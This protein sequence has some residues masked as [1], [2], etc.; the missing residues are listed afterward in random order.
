MSIYLT[1]VHHISYHQARRVGG[2]SPAGICTCIEG[3]QLCQSLPWAPAS[4][5]GSRTS[6]PLAADISIHEG[7]VGVE[8]L[9]IFNLN[10]PV[11]ISYHRPFFCLCWRLLWCV[12]EL[13]VCC[14]QAKVLLSQL[15]PASITKVSKVQNIILSYIGWWFP[16]SFVICGKANSLLSHL[17]AVELR[18]WNFVW[19]LSRHFM[20]QYIVFLVFITLEIFLWPL[21]FILW[22]L[23]LHQH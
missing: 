18:K 1:R 17:W 13:V 5:G 19:I 6:P 15:Q 22:S 20:S 21:W 7:L 9:Y 12:G 14:L 4:H 2:K 10:F 8:V 3:A 16:N 11:L 23:L